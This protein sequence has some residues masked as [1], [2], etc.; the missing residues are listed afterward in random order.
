MFGGGL[1]VRPAIHWSAGNA[2]EHHDLARSR[3]GQGRENEILPNIGDEV[4]ANRGIRLAWEHAS[5]IG[6]SKRPLW[7]GKWRAAG[8]TF[9]GVTDSSLAAG[10][11]HHVMAAR[12]ALEIIDARGLDPQ[13]SASL[14]ELSHPARDLHPLIHGQGEIVEARSPVNY[15]AA[16]E[17]RNGESNAF[18][19]GTYLL[20]IIQAQAPFGFQCRVEHALARHHSAVVDFVRR[21]IGKKSDS[22]PSAQQA[23]TELQA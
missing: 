3:G 6:E 16:N 12:T 20:P 13:V 21:A 17:I 2:L 18:N 5:D 10:D 14:L 8:L 15:F 23:E 1:D 19:F 9:E 11:D 4:E 22:V 7:F